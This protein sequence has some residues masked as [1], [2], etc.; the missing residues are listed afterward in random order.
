[1]DCVYNSE[2]EWIANEW[3]NKMLTKEDNC[4]QYGVEMFSSLCYACGNQQDYESRHKN[5]QMNNGVKQHIGC[6]KN[7]WQT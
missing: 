5:E 1:M 3:I 4:T 2:K 6:A 7:P